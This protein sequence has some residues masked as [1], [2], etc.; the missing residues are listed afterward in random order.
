MNQTNPD[1][2]PLHT[3]NPLSRFS[4]RAG[5]YVKYRP[6]YPASA[7]DII[8]EGLAPP[9]QLIAADIGAG[10]GISSRLL[11]LRDVNVIAIEPNAAMRE[12]AEPHPRVEFRD[13]TAEVTNIAD[14]SVDLVTCF[15]AFH[16][17]NPEPTLLEFR[18]ILKQSGRLA[19]VWN[20]RDLNDEFTAEYS[21]VIRTASSNHPAEA[22]M[23]SVEPLLTTSYFVNMREYTFVYRQELDLTGLIGRAM[24][25]S[26]L[27]RKGTVNQ[28]LISA[29]QELYQRFCDESG[30]VYMVYST[31]VHLADAIKN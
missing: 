2:T 21:R 18:R 10:T 15:Q 24:S 6:S 30:F 4:D 31:S 14:A 23:K 11:A 13:G 29:L 8:L 16:W 3:L 1:A 9:S 25:S 17:F 28:Q 7:I 5:D 26:Y 27:P 12:V 19:L 20:N 22:R